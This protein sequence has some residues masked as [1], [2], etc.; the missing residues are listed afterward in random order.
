MNFK[1]IYFIL[2]FTFAILQWGCGSVPPSNASREE[3][4]LDFTKSKVEKLWDYDKEHK[5]EIAKDLYIR[6]LTD[7]Y[8]EKYVSAI[9]YFETALKYEENTT[10]HLMLAEC[11]MQIR[12]V[13]NSL[14]H[15]MQVFL[16]DTNNTRSLQLMF[17]GFI[18]KNDITS[19]ERTINYI[20]SKDQSIENTAMLAE[21]YSYTNPAKAIEI[22]DNLLF[23]TG[24]KEYGLKSLDLYAKT[25]NFRE[26]IKK[27]YNYLKDNYDPDYFRILFYTS[28]DNKYY[29]YIIRYYSEIY[30]KTS[31]DIKIETG[32]SF[33]DLFYFTNREIADSDFKLFIEKNI[34]SILK[35]YYELDG[36]TKTNSNEQ[37]GFIAFDSGDTTLAVAFWLK[38]LENCDS[39]R[40]LSKFVPYYCLQ[41]GK[42]EIGLKIL[43]EFHDRY[44]E[45]ST[46]LLNLGFY[47]I[48]QNNYKTALNYFRDYLT[49]DFNNL[50][51]ITSL[52]DCY[53]NLK[54]FTDAEKYYLKALKLEPD[55]PTVNNNYAYLLTNKKDRLADALKF[56]EIALKLE[57][58]N[59]AY[60]D[61]YAWV[62]FKMGNYEIAKEY[63][64]K[65]LSIGFENAE[66]Y[67]HLYEVNFKMGFYN[68]ASK[69]LQKAL[70]IEPDNADY[71]KKLKEI[72]KK[73]K[74]R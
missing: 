24:D 32:L 36:G 69:Y 31:E 47:F 65:A 1:Y 70:T 3:T 50:I 71:K 6:G 8:D 48:S 37:I 18:L 38:K 4:F 35:E 33:L 11:Y 34:K 30:P 17:S 5:Q 55:D 14:Y 43:R 58:D 22:Y 44:P 29:D 57:P 45:D 42:P 23:R 28:I 64:E 54:N 41:I 10:L 67:E 40:A 56:A 27:S 20:Q 7:Y 15:S 52:A 53:S 60:L 51:A 61:T 13:D 59:G 2:L 19:A 63:L 66:L 39:C 26:A 21:F 46:Y 73:Q 62:H 72:E 68:E 74:N 9:L 16:R 49:K 12:D 25:G